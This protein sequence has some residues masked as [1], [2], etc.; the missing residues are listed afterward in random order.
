MFTRLFTKLYGG[1]V[2]KIY[3]ILLKTIS[4]T[5]YRNKNS[6]CFKEFR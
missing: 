4:S 3:N 5:V 2:A 1:A 6:L